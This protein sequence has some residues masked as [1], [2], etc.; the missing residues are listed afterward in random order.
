MA[1]SRSKREFERLTSS[2][3]R[4]QVVPTPGNNS[5][6]SAA[7]SESSTMP[8]LPPLARAATRW[9]FN[10]SGGD[11]QMVKRFLL[12]YS[13]IPSN[14]VRSLSSASFAAERE[15]RLEKLVRNDRLSAGALSVGW[16]RPSGW[17]ERSGSAAGLLSLCED[18]V[19]RR[20]SGPRA[21]PHQSCGRDGGASVLPAA[22]RAGG[23]KRRP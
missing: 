7:L 1:T 9:N 14:F 5:G 3:W 19:S 22:A 6:S 8:D 11:S 23:G 15:P 2:R 13:S 10:A 16:S 4:A 18:G 17:R 20:G 12:I 21:G